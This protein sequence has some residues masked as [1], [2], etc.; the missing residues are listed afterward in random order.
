MVRDKKRTG[1]YRGR[2]SQGS[3]N[4]KNRGRRSSK[5]GRGQSG[6]KK[7]CKSWVIKYDKDHFG[8]RGFKREKKEVPVLNLYEIENMIKNGKIKKEGD[9]YDYSFKGKILGT[10]LLNYPVS[11]KALKWSRKAEEKIKKASGEISSLK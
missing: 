10:G 7:H 2:R 6:L 5:G 8:S 9:R 3:G 4:V 11:L 1:S